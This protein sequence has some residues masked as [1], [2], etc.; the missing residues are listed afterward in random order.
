MYRY[1]K[2]L[3]VVL[4]TGLLLPAPGVMAQDSFGRFFTTPKQREQLD[5]KRFKE[6][7]QEL[8][9]EV[10]ETG[11]ME[12]KEQEDPVSVG[13][14]Q[15]KGLVYRGDGKSTAWTNKGPSYEGNISDQYLEIRP[16]NINPDKVVIEIPTSDI[17]VE[18]KAGETYSPES[19]QVEKDTAAD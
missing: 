19:G 14:V 8:V 5:Q 10:D 4:S 6:P 11:F 18:L 16:E 1:V 15:L 12:E 17:Q 9:V 3:L 7:G 2:I 13:S